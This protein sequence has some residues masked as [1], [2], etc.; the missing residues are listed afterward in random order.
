MLVRARVVGER[1]R[2]RIIDQGPGIRPAISS[3]SSCRST[4]RP[5]SGAGHQGS[6][7]GL[8]IAKGFVEANGGRIT[9]ESLPGQ[10]TSFIV[11]LPLE[12]RG[13]RRA[14]G[15]VMAGERILVCDDDPQILRALR[16]VLRGAGYEVLTSTTA[17]GGARPRRDRRR[18]TP[19]SST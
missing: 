17:R 11:E 12:P 10:G 1:V 16:L 7:L 6:G 18:R 5:G 15:R 3:G 13:R 8:A 9:V 4:A 2:V 19:R 14:G